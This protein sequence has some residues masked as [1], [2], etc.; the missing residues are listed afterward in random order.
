MGAVVPRPAR[1]TLTAVL[2]TLA[3]VAALGACSSSANHTSGGTIASTVVAGP[4]TSAP[5]LPP[6]TPIAIPTATDGVSPDGSGCDP[7]AGNTLPT[8]IWYGILRSVDP[9]A[10]TIGLDLACWFSGKSA[11][12]ASGSSAPVADDVYVRNQNPKIY[13]IP[14]AAKVAVVPLATTPAGG[15][16]GGFAPN[17]TGIAAAQQVATNGSDHGVWVVITDGQAVVIQAQFRP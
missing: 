3:T 10:N 12:A 9:P 7:P 2:A 4:A 16:S 8:G 11:Q 14:V 5:P 1:R 13:T 6:K 17:A 15:F